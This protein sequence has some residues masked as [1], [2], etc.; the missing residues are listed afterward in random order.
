MYQNVFFGPLL[1]N[2]TVDQSLIDV[3]LEEGNK[4]DL[5]MRPFLAGVLDKEL[6]Y[7]DQQLEVIVPL[8]G[9]YIEKYIEQQ[10]NITQ[11]PINDYDIDFETIWINYQYP[12]NYNPLHSHNR[13]I[14]FIIYCDIPEA[15]SQEKSINQAPKPGAVSFYDGTTSSYGEKATKFLE[16]IRQ[17]D[18]LPKTGDMFIFPAYLN[19]C[20]QAFRSD[21]VRISVSGNVR[22]LNVT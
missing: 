8:I 18:F 10:K 11:Y 13:D 17:V 5:D 19:H 3:L 22:L 21:V 20:V 12:G 7:T 4:T 15:I 2:T 1:V 9:P 14:S 6:R 16:P